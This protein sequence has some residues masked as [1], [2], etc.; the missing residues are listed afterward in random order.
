MKIKYSL[1]LKITL[2]AIFFIAAFVFCCYFGI[3]KYSE[4]YIYSDIKKLPKKDF[5]IVLGTNKKL[6]DGRINPFY[7][8]RID[9]A[10][11]LYRNAKVKYLIVSGA[12]PSIYYNEPED[13]KKDLMAAGIP[14]NHIQADYAGRRT[15]DSLLRAEKIFDISDY[16]IISQKFH[17][18]RAIFLARFNGHQAIAFNA[19]DTVLKKRSKKVRIREIGAR[20]KAVLDIVF[21]KK[22]K[23]YGEKITF[24][25]NKN[26]LEKQAENKLKNNLKNN[27][28]IDN[29]ENHQKAERPNFVI[30]EN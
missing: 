24:P 13:M 30:K 21:H 11:D 16:L 26:K 3:E 22:A 19:R 9:A 29:K 6:K 17:N 10:V 14:E 20:C 18:Q 5:A 25:D 4:K 27:L 2:A 28:E 8:N 15:L 23:I 12:N 1:I 7:K